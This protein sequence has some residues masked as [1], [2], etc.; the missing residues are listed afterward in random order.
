MIRPLRLFLADVL[1]VVDGH[2]FKRLVLPV[3]VQQHAA[4]QAIDAAAAVQAPGQCFIV[5][6]RAETG[7]QA[8]QRRSRRNCGIE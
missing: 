1:G 7:M 5:E 3:V 2:G 8:E 6:D 4:L